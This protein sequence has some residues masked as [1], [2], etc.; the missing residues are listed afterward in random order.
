MKEI[1][2]L[3]ENSVI[4]LQE[5]CKH[6]L[7]INNRDLN[8]LCTNIDGVLPASSYI[9]RLVPD[10]VVILAR[11]G[12]SVNYQVNDLGEALLKHHLDNPDERRYQATPGSGAKRK[13]KKKKKKPKAA[14]LPPVVPL[15]E[16]P[17]EFMSEVAKAAM[18]DLYPAIDRGRTLNK[19]LHVIIS[20]CVEI[21]DADPGTDGDSN[22]DTE[23]D[24]LLDYIEK[25]Y[26]ETMEMRV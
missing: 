16:D 21:M 25:V 24:G 8:A 6:P 1:L 18:N 14:A 22:L 13:T 10:H 15:Q 19:A 12:N 23:N 20:T 17:E 7:G 26:T 11:V 3:T 2:L 9:N 5:L 4:A